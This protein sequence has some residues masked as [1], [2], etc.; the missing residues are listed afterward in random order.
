LYRQGGGYDEASFAQINKTDA[1]GHLKLK[2]SQPGV[3]L[4]MARHRG[5]APPGAATPYRSYTTSL[6]FEVAR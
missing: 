2:F 6:T 3:Y 5:D 4:I 1:G